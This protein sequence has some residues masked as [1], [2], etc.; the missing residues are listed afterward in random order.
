MIKE[1]N[2]SSQERARA[3][4]DMQ[5]WAAACPI[6][7]LS[8][9]ACVMDFSLA[10]AAPGRLTHSRLCRRPTTARK[11]G[12]VVG[13]GGGDEGAIKIQR[14][15]PPVLMQSLCRGMGRRECNEILP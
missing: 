10:R 12:G 6:V 11:S 5:D 2:T 9:N 7:G 4:D 8:A 1:V 14:A 3:R 13:E 15:A